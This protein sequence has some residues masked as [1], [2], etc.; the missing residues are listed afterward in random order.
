MDRADPLVAR[1][2]ATAASRCPAAA[3]SA[4]A[5]P[6]S[7]AARSAAAPSARAELVDHP[8][9][10][11]SACSPCSSLLIVF[12][13]SRTTWRP[14]AP[15]RLARRR[16]WGQ[17]LVGRAACTPSG[18][19]LFVGIGRRARPDLARRDAAPGA[20]PPR[21][22][23]PRDRDRGREQR[24][25][26]SSSCVA[27]GTALTLLGLGLVHGGDRARARRDRR[28]PAD[29]RRCAPTG[30]RLDAHPAAARRALDRGAR[31][32]AA[33]EP[34]FLAAD[35]GLARGPLGAD[36][37]RRSSSRTRSALGALRRSGH[38]VARRLAEGR[39]ADRRRAARSRSSPGRSSACC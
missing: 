18:S 22:E 28:R 2:G 11:A 33:R 4:R 34:I 6:T 39:V 5:R 13:L 15:L 30:S 9:A 25:S 32:L 21:V 26:S 38:L 27:I 35:R 19:W 12:L 31:R 3:R 20:R 16:A 14:S 23:L 29:R 37:R 24:A 17:I 36:R 1:T 7:S 10:V 8:L